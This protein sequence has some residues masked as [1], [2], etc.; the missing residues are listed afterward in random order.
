MRR[1]IPWAAIPAIVVDQDF[2]LRVSHPREQLAAVAPLL[3]ARITTWSPLRHWN[4]GPG[5]KVGIVGI[6]GL[7][8]GDQAGKCAGAETYAFHH[9]PPSG[10]RH[11]RSGRRA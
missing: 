8:H 4:V 3:C 2:V 5:K 11:W 7:G 1:G 10:T 6:S 9:Q